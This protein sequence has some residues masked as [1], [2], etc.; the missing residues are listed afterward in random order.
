MQIRPATDADSLAYLALRQA[1]WPDETRDRHMVHI[2]Q[3]LRAAQDG[4]VTL[5]AFSEARKCVGFAEAALRQDYVNGCTTSPVAFLEGIYVDPAHRKQGIARHL[6][7]RVFAW[8]RQQGC[9]EIASDA[10]LDNTGSHAMHT[11]L[12]FQETERV[13]F[14][15][16]RLVPPARPPLAAPAIPA[17][18]AEE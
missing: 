4:I 16:H 13:V 7:D 15:R 8:A 10:A 17:I 3:S 6:I 2:Q 5:L 1:L 12:G 9:T 18:R 14:F 11:A